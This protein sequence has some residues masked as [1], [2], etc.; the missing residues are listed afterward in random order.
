MTDPDAYHMSYYGIA[1]IVFFLVLFGAI[2]RAV[3]LISWKY[4]VALFAGLVFDAIFFL[5]LS[6]GADD[7]EVYLL[8]ILVHLGLAYMFYYKFVMREEF[9][10]PVIPALLIEK[11]RH[12]DLPFGRVFLYLPH[13]LFV[14]MIIWIFVKFVIPMFA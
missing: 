10:K 13:V 4:L 14:V 7:I 9:L 2:Y 11:S 3:W 6:S 12:E 1:H 5:S 8:V